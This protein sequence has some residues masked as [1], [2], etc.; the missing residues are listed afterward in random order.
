M[1]NNASFSLWECNVENGE[2]KPKREIAKLENGKNIRLSFKDIIYYKCNDSAKTVDLKYNTMTNHTM[3]NEEFDKYKSA[4]PGFTKGLI[5]YYEK[6]TRLLAEIVEKELGDTVKNS[7]KQYK[8]IL[9]FDEK[10][11]KQIKLDFAP[12]VTDIQKAVSKYNEIQNYI[13]KTSNAKLSA[14]QGTLKMDLCRKCNRTN[15]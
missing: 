13:Y 1:I 12:E 14:H 9:T 4:N 5:W 15:A 6:E 3:P 7:D 8:I 2:L 10:T 11:Y